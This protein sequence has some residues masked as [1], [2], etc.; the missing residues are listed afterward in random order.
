MHDGMLCDPIR[1][2]GHKILKVG[3]SLFSTSVSSAICNGS[4]Q[5]TA[6]S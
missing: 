5:M 6:G 4:W 1:G 3:N 2:Q